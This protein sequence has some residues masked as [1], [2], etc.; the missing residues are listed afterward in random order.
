MAEI[1][2]KN[3]SEFLKSLPEDRRKALSA[4]RRVILDNLGDGFEETARWGG[5]SYEVPLSVLSDTYNGQPLMLAGLMNGKNGMSLHLLCAYA[6]EKLDQRFRKEYLATGKRLDMGKGCVRFRK[7][8]D[9]PLDV[10]GRTIASVSLSK[11]V[12]CYREARE[13]RAAGAAK[14]KAPKKR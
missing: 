13:K 11:Y 2:A 3:P 6:D 9:L 7:L 8:D 4:V 14:A 5:I 1:D 10:V 12:E